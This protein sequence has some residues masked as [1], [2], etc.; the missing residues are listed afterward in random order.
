MNKKRDKRF[1]KSVLLMTVMVVSLSA[2]GAESGSQESVQSL[3]QQ[4]VS[5]SMTHPEEVQMTDKY[6]AIGEVI[7]EKRI[8][9]YANGG[10]SIEAIWVK[11]GDEVSPNDPLISLSDSTVTYNYQATESSLRTVKETAKVSLDQAKESY[12]ESKVLYETGAIS[13]DTLESA[14]TQLE[15]AQKKYNDA[16][17]NYNNQVSNLRESVDD[18]IISSPIKGSV[19][20]IEVNQGD[21][22]SNQLAVTVIDQSSVKIKTAI[23]GEIKKT[24][25]TGDKVMIYIDGNYENVEEGVIVT[26]N[27]IPDLQTKLFDLEIETKKPLILGEY[28][29]VGLVKQTLETWAVPAESIIREG[30]QAYL[31]LST[32]DGVEKIEVNTGLSDGNWIGVDV[33]DETLSINGDTQV[34]LDGF[35]KISVGQPVEDINK[36]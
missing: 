23:P 18:R 35:D 32:T 6:M 24:L 3:S 16:V 9:L 7:P 14:N 10:G 17:V 30:N 22:V 28:V 5:V 34:I 2:C 4:V 33:L 27:E 26:I 36:N 25:Q 20:A 12:E 1:I 11:I 29:E 21:P 31:Y 13:Q 19:A 15:L 8:D